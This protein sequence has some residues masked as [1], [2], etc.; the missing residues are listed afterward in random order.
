MTH[1]LVEFS[2]LIVAIQ[3]NIARQVHNSTAANHNTLFMEILGDKLALADPG[4]TRVPFGIAG[5]KNNQVK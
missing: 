3:T 5:L 2:G 1:F 4:Y